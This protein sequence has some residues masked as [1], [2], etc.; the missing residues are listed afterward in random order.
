VTIVSATQ[1]VAVYLAT[2]FPNDIW[3]RKKQYFGSSE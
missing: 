1:T 3:L 2:K